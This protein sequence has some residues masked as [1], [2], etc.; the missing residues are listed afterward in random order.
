V[1]TK[2]RPARSGDS[3]QSPRVGVRSG[4]ESGVDPL[5]FD[6]FYR[7]NRMGSFAFTP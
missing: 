1:L 5:F 3:S 7:F 6:P 2:R 4:I